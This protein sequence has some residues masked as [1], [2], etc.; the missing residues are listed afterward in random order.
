MSK[1]FRP[2]H[3]ALQESHDSRRLATADADECPNCSFKGGD[4]GFVRVTGDS[5]LVFPRYDGNGMFLP[6]GNATGNPNVA[7]APACQR[8]SPH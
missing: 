8:H 7:K 3:R 6:M 4:P 1:L 5:E 2:S